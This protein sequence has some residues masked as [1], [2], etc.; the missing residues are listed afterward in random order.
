MRPDSVHVVLV[1]PA[2][3]ANVAAACRAMKNMGLR[4]LRLV[5]AD[6]GLSAADAR[7]LAYGAWDVLDGIVFMPTLRDAV[8]DC[9]LVAGTTGRAS[10]EAWSPRQLATEAATRTAAESLALVFGPEA[11]LDACHLRVHIPADPAHPSLNLAQ[12][13][14]ILAYELRV[15]LAF[16]PDP[17]GERTAMAA[18]APL[19]TPGPLAGAEQ[20]AGAGQLEEALDG[21]REAL[22]AIGYLSPANPEAILAEIRR[23]LARARPTARETTLLRGMARQILWAAR[24]VA[25]GPRPGG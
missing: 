2:R 5:G 12:A 10:A 21:L 19:A 13:V 20:L 9:T 3:A 6:P 15:A 23:L 16:A 14:L 7:A 24:R 22:L 17:D 25:T 4:S 18:T 11:R 1:R 8:A